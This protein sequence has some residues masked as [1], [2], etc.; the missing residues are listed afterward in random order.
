MTT[1]YRNWKIAWDPNN[2]Y[3][4]LENWDISALPWS[5]RR[6]TDWFFYVKR[7]SYVPYRD[8]AWVPVNEKWNITDVYYSNNKWC[9]WWECYKY[10]YVVNS[11]RD[12]YI[13]L[14]KDCDSCNITVL[15][16]WD[17]CP[18]AEDRFFETLWP[19]LP[20]VDVIQERGSSQMYNADTFGYLNISW[21]D[22]DNIKPWDFISIM[23]IWVWS[24]AVCW[25]SRQVLAKIPYEWEENWDYTLQ[26]SQ[27]WTNINTWDV[28]NWV[29]YVVSEFVSNM[30]SFISK[31]WIRQI[32]NWNLWTAVC[33]FSDNTC[34]L[35]V[36]SHNWTLT[37]LTDK[38]FNLY[39]W[40][41]LDA[42]S[43]SATN[44]NFVGKDKIQSVSFKNFLVFFWNNSI[45]TIVFS[46]DWSTSSYYPL[47]NDIGIHNK[48]AYE[49]FDNWLYFIGNDNRVYWASI[50]WNNG[51]FQIELQDIT[52]NV[53]PHMDLIQEWDNVY[54]SS[55]SDR[56]YIFINW[57]DDDRNVWF[58]KTK[59]LIYDK[60][61]WIRLVHTICWA[62]ITGNRF[63]EFIGENI[64]EYWGR[65]WDGIN[66]KNWI[67]FRP[68]TA[69]AE[70]ILYKNDNHWMRDSTDIPLDM[71]RRHKLSNI[72]L[73]L[74]Q[75]RY[76]K[77]STYLLIDKYDKY[78]YSKAYWIDDSNE[79][80]QKRNDAMNW[81]VVEPSDCFKSFLWK[82]DNIK[83]EAEWSHKNYKVE[84]KFCSWIEERRVFEDYCI[85]YDDN[86]Y[87]LSP[88]HKFMMNFDETDADFWKVSFISDWFDLAY[89][90]WFIIETESDK[91]FDADVDNFSEW[92]CD[93]I[94]YCPNKS[95]P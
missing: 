59:I 50:S 81:E 67:I 34:I 30:P 46:E 66:E 29:Y 91:S 49:L 85:K 27:P 11:S 32:N 56:L 68:Y 86:F 75:W 36:Q 74:W 4:T 7:K 17:R 31:Y 5:L 77:E 35:S 95:C 33:D 14:K 80:I 3:E 53:Y 51:V 79:I 9:V 18:C 60:T 58:S 25:Q 24:N 41:W 28:Y 89:F 42:N 54:M 92:C 47:R 61:Y 76:S 64:Y 83:N 62:M 57:K 2:V 15:E 10:Y 16:S 45:S 23:R 39:G 69:K 44:N 21:S 88:I 12:R 93:K 63:W 71:F 13:V 82:C 38:W 55:Y 84:K 37:Y 73:L 26:L 70:A 87:A 20:W 22:Q 94:K 78:K 43:I 90:G 40:T 8:R 65:D 1:W 72:V 6:D 52:K 19:D 48:W